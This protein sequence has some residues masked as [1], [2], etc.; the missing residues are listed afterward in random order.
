M[1]AHKHDMSLDSP[2]PHALVV[3]FPAQGH[4]GPMM[5]LSI[6]LAM[7]AGFVITFVNTH[8][9]HASLKQL[10]EPRFH[11][12]G[13][14]HIH[15]A[16]VVNAERDSGDTTG[17]KGLVELCESF[18]KLGPAYE[19]LVESLL[20]TGHDS[21]DWANPSAN[22]S[23]PPP[24]T[25]IISDMF[26]YFMQDIANKFGLKYVAFWTASAGMLAKVMSVVAHGHRAP[27]PA[28]EEEQV[29]EQEQEQEEEEPLI[30][31]VPGV[32]ALK[33]SEFHEFLLNP[34]PEDLMYDIYHTSYR[35]LREA[36]CVA[37]NTFEE[38][39]AESLAALRMDNEP[40]EIYSVGPLL[41]D[42]YFNNASE[43]PAKNGDGGGQQ[44]ARKMKHEIL[45]T[46]HRLSMPSMVGQPPE[47]KGES[48]GFC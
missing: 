17:S 29:Q 21:N 1:S 11:E 12:H 45:P 26:N 25:C 9:H 42:S 33:R 38:L 47:G 2:R 7:D 23:S 18:Y 40:L 15:L 19:D 43:R 8:H 48:R 5:H 24:L 35:R 32:P 31:W 10:L 22:L 13:L 30:T 27:P 3:P 36:A 37:I 46:A 4:I 39:E 16:Q 41:P 34:D 14:H 20:P 28:H 44:P 6:K